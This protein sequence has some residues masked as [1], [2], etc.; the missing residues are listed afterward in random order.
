MSGKVEGNISWYMETVL[1]DLTAR[2]LIVKTGVKPVK[3]KL[4]KQG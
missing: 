1:L 2:G 4:I 3:L